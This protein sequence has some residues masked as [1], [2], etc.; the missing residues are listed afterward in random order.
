MSA[1]RGRSTGLVILAVAILL[2]AALVVWR[3]GHAAVEEAPEDLT[4]PPVEL[5]EAP[6]VPTPDPPAIPTPGPT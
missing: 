1:G 4:L 5:P 6:A 2:V 3:L